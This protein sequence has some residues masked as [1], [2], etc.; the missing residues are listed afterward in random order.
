MSTAVLY[1]LQQHS[2]KT[3]DLIRW[4]CEDFLQM[5]PGILRDETVLRTEHGK[6]YLPGLPVEVSVSHT[7]RL[8]AALVAEEEAGPV[9]LDVQSMRTAPFERIAQR[10]FT[11]EEY[12]YVRQ[13][14][15]EG[16]YRLWT[17]KEAL[18]KYWGLPLLDT[19]GKQSLVDEKGNIEAPEGI[20]FRE[21]YLDPQILAAMAWQ[22]DRMVELCRK[23]MN[24]KQY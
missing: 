10:F 21:L 22:A 24:E 17:R 12:D 9:G 3:D 19:C 4:L 8:F 16:F 1:V 2:K 20:L 7:G 23:E 5:P 13:T 6:P 11:E 14:G 18:T 15:K